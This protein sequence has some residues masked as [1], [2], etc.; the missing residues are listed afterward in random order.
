MTDILEQIRLCGLL[1]CLTGDSA[2]DVA[3]Y[4]YAL[5]ARGFPAVEIAYPSSGWENE[6]FEALLRNAEIDVIVQAR[7]MKQRALALKAGARWVS[8]PYAQRYSAGF[9]MAETDTSAVCMYETEMFEKPPG[10]NRIVRLMIDGNN[11]FS[12]EQTQTFKQILIFQNQQSV[13]AGQAATY[14]DALKRMWADSLEFSLVHIGINASGSHEAANIAR[15]YSGLLGV[16]YIY[17][18]TSDY[19]GTSI[20]VMKDKGRGTHGHIGIA[21]NDLERGMYF[22]QRSG[23]SFDPDSRK[24]DASG[25]AILYYLTAELGGFAV[26]LLQK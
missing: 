1:P 9:P 26:H 18:N 14:A 4:L 10:V 21:T 20:E 16:P 5:S 15:K 25:R 2:D 17:G 11:G 7:D 19:A 23:F 3:S 12:C 13:R 22:A 6:K 24:N 8:L